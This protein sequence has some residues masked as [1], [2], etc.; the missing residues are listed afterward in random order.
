MESP[1]LGE[2]SGGKTGTMFF[3]VVKD[4]V[5]INKRNKE[6]DNE[7]IRGFRGRISVG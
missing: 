1:S 5:E 7:S 4:V 6:I 2:R 3:I